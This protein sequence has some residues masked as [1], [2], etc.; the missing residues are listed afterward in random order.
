MRQML[1][2]V[3]DELHSRLTLA[4]RKSGRSVNALAND[5]LARAVPAEPMDERTRLREKARQLGI[6]VERPRTSAVDTDR[7]RRALASTEGIGPAL[8]KIF[9]EG[10]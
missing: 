4:A 1:L 9:E 8:D 3:P 10:R 2:R 5:I 7:W 6:L